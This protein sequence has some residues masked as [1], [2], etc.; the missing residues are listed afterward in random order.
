VLEAKVPTPSLA[1]SSSSSPEATPKPISKS[2]EVEEESPLEFPFE[3]EDNLFE[4]SR[5][6]E[7]YPLQARPSLKKHFDL[8][9]E[10]F[11]REDL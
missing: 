2:L 11:S 8:F 5:N 9:D 7:N 4:D 3:I 6:V 10:E 1:Q